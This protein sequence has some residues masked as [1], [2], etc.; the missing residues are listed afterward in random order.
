LQIALQF[1]S[2]HLNGYSVDASTG[3]T[4]HSLERSFERGDVDVMQ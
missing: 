4:T 2:V 3:S 1:L